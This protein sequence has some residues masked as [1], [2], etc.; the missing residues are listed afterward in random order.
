MRSERKMVITKNTKEIQ[1]MIKEYFK[2]LHSN[3]LKNIEEVGKLLHAFDLSKLN[4]EDI[5]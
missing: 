1:R 5:K 4:Q 2:N 3:K